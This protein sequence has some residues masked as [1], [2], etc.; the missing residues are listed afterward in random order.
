MSVVTFY[1]SNKIETAQTTSM[2]GIATH[3]SIEKNYKTLLLNTK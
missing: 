3:L 2:A 1:G